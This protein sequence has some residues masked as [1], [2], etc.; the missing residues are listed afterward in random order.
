[1]KS[2]NRVKE[3]R[4]KNHFNGNIGAAVIVSALAV[5]STSAVAADNPFATTM[6]PH[7]NAI[8]ATP[9]RP[10]GKCG[11]GCCGSPTSPEC[12]AEGSTPSSP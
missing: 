9:T 12:I 5:P 11:E 8:Q 2:E 7:S 3:S 10:E 4:F 1:M 6:L